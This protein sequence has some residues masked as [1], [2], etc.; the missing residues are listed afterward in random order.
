M[1]C[2]NGYKWRR[3]KSQNLTSQISSPKI[4]W[5]KRGCCVSVPRVWVISSGFISTASG[6]DTKNSPLRRTRT[7]CKRGLHPLAFSGENS[8]G[9][10]KGGAVNQPNDVD[11]PQ[12]VSTQQGGRAAAVYTLHAIFKRLKRWTSAFSQP[13]C[14]LNNDPLTVADSQHT[15]NLHR[16]AVSM[17]SS[18]K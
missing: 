8:W 3:N 17:T 7:Q 14:C 6:E 11:Y 1:L 15:G 4:K 18:V 9:Q 13:E 2:W 12:M 10:W 5:G 16:T